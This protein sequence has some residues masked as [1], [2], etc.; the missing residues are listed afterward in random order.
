MRALAEKGELRR[1]GRGLFAITNAWEDDLYILQRKYA[2]GIY[3]HETA[4]YLLGYSDR[5]PARYTMTF[6]K[7]YN[8]PSIK[9][10]NVIVK[11][12][13]PKNYS[14]GVVEV[15]SPSGSPLLIYDLERSI[16]DVLRGG[17]VDVQV[18][19]DAMKRYVASEEANIHKL[20]QFAERLR[21]KPKVMRYLEVLL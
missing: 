4:L 10:E 2:R 16:C 9:Q 20:T 7:G 8:A 15:K 5:T 3:S 11:R 1:V 12:V 6:P 13:L 21:V 19:G 18:V 17:V 14:W